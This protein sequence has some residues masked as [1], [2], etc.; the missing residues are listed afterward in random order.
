MWALALCHFVV[1]AS[2]QETAFAQC[3]LHYWVSIRAL[4]ILTTVSTVCMNTTL[5][6]FWILLHLD[7]SL[8]FECAVFLISVRTMTCPPIHLWENEAII[9][10]IHTLIETVWINLIH[11]SLMCVR[12]VK[13]LNIF[14]FSYPVNA[15]ACFLSL[16]KSAVN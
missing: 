16:D 12:S 5:K 15:H 4:S 13:G 6:H 1:K 9:E 14:H 7:V 8:S 10:T 11:W 3:N 2:K